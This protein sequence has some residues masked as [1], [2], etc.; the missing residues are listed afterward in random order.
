[1]LTSTSV[2]PASRKPLQRALADLAELGIEIVPE[3]LARHAEA[4][5]LQRGRRNLER[6]R[7]SRRRRCST[8]SATLRVIGPG[9]IARVRD[10]HDAGLR[11]AAGGRAKTDDAAQRRR[12]AH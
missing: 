8:Q 5:P 7:R 6:A 2:T 1:M 4:Q 12:D 9:G 11:P 3:M 10:R